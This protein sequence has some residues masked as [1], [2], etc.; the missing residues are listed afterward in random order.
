[1]GLVWISSFV[2]PGLDRRFGWSS[3]ENLALGHPY[4]MYWDDPALKM[5]ASE[6]SPFK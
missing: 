2:V 3:N 4:T 5:P 1:M 6:S